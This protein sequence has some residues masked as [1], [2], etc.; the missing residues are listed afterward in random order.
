MF[1]TRSIRNRD[2]SLFLIP[3]IL[4]IFTFSTY[5]DAHYNSSS[6]S[7]IFS[8]EDTEDLTCLHNTILKE[9]QYGFSSDTL[10]MPDAA[11]TYK[12]AARSFLNDHPVAFF[13]LSYDLSHPFRAPPSVS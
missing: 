12:T 10:I 5:D 1:L 7:L 4:F 11:G 2:P 13:P 3:L 6:D 9:G 8:Q